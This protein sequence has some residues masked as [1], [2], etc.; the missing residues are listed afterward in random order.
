MYIT[1]INSKIRKLCEDHKLA[2]RKLGEHMTKKLFQRIAEIRA[3]E[4]L[5]VLK[6]LPAPRC[7]PLTN[8]RQG[9]Y[10]VDLMHP[11]RL[12]LLP[13]CEGEFIEK[14]IT[15]VVIVEIIDYH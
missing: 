2:Q 8:N 15:D 14:L 3:A 6:T 4:N 1:F 10:A 13:I 9:Q 7:H 12:I 11:K 5:A